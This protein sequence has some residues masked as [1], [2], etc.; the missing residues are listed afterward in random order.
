MLGAIAPSYELA[1]HELTH[2]LFSSNWN[3]N[4]SFLSEGIAMYAQDMSIESNA[5][6]VATY[7]YLRN[8][9]LMPLSKMVNMDIGEDDN[10]KMGYYASGSFVQFIIEKWGQKTFLELWKTDREWKQIYG[11]SLTELEQE[12][13]NWLSKKV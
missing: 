1:V 4:C 12:W 11:K 3:G 6:N 10:A 7:N 2:K 13:H 8:N 5:N 9:E